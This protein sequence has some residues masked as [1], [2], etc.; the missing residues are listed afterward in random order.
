MSAVKTA[1][2]TRIE[3]Q[4]FVDD[5]HLLSDECPTTVEIYL[6]AAVSEFEVKTGWTPLADGTSDTVYFDAPLGDYLDLDGAFYGVT[7][8]TVDLT[9][10]NS[11]GTVLTNHTDY[12]LWPYDGPPYTRVVLLSGPY[13]GP[14]NTPGGHASGLRSIKVVG[15]QGQNV[16]IPYDIWLA[17]L[18]R[19][20]A[21]CVMALTAQGGIVTDVT[22]GPVKLS[23]Q[24]GNSKI[25]QFRAA[26]DCAVAR[27]RRVV[28]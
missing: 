14:C 2:P 6:D 20:T 25:E 5:S 10:T 3:L 27:N 18:Q 23:Y 15:R 28:L 11:V 16:S 7:S 8:V 21:E 13:A 19:A 1:W 22:Q 24:K 26:F 12:E 9:P 17:V 4:T